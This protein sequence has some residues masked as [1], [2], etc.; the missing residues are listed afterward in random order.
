M[1]ACPFWFELYA[2]TDFISDIWQSKGHPILVSCDH[3]HQCLTEN[4]MHISFLSRSSAYPVDEPT[5][6]NHWRCRTHGKETVCVFLCHNVSVISIVADW[7]NSGNDRKELGGASSN[8]LQRTEN[9]VDCHWSL[10]RC[11]LEITWRTFPGR[12]PRERINLTP[13]VRPPGAVSFNFIHNAYLPTNAVFP[14]L[15]IEELV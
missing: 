12:R 7:R 13:T 4:T 6:S 3:W 11:A 2:T 1:H 15:I 10:K 9:F 14:V 8:L 5:S